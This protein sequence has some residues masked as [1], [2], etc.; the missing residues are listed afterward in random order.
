MVNPLLLSSVCLYMASHLPC[1]CNGL[2][3]GDSITEG[4][5]TIAASGDAT[6]K[7][8]GVM[9]WAYESGRLLGAEFGVVGFGGQGIV[10]TGAGSVPAITSTYGSICPGR[11]KVVFANARLGI[12][13][14]IGTNDGTSNTTTAMTTLLNGLLRQQR[15]QRLLF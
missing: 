11:C 9:G 1:H 12:C 13:V 2:Y 7:E 3:Y 8:D 10:A 15:Q 14:N 6:V 4:S 5:I